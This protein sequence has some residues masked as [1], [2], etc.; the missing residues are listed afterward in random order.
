[1]PS[2]RVQCNI[3]SNQREKGSDVGYGTSVDQGCERKTEKS[4]ACSE[5]LELQE[6]LLLGMIMLTLVRG[7]E[8]L[9]T[10]PD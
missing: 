9:P 8:I 6:K 10:G 2:G 1:M 4:C 7:S 3:L 5:Y